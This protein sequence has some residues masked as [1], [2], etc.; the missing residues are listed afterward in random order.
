M[1]NVMINGIIIAGPTGIGKTPLAHIIAMTQ[2][3]MLI[4]R[5]DLDEK[6]TFKSTN[7]LDFLRSEPGRLYTP[8]IYDDGSM[9]KDTAVALKA[10]FDLTCEDAKVYARWGAS[11]FE[12]GQL[13]IACTN[14]FVADAE[15]DV[16]EG[17]MI[18]HTVFRN[19]IG[20]TFDNTWDPE[21]LMAVL[22]RVT[23]IVFGRKHAY[24]REANPR[25]V[26]V[27]CFSYP[28]DN[29]DVLVPGCKE[30]MTDCM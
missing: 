29:R 13:R 10:Y 14:N 27:K 19:I 18:E 20:N 12:P 22:K 1:K 11:S 24:L 28:D 7:H 15:P 26:Y 4:A 9:N 6:A 25:P 3:A 30:L 2:S 8:I 17:D 21:D 16:A 23:M 5:D